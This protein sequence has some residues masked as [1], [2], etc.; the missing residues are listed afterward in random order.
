LVTSSYETSSNTAK[1]KS[2]VKTQSDTTDTTHID[3][4]KIED[5]TIVIHKIF[6]EGTITKIDKARKYIYVRFAV[7]EKQFAMQFALDN[8]FLKLK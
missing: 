3:T 1:A 6:G 4:S 7:G 8:G 5:G 2:A